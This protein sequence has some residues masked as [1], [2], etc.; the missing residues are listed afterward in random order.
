MSSES[1]HDERTKDESFSHDGGKSLQI[2][3]PSP[4][5]KLTINNNTVCSIKL[6][7]TIK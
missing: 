2:F 1:L 5:D 4:K 3:L 6:N 7:E